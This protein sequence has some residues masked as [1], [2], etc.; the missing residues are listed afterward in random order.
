MPIYA[1]KCSACGFAKDAL[2]KMSDAPLTV[3]P[4]CGASTFEKQVTAAGFQ[5]KGSGWYVTDF[6][7]GGSGKKPGPPVPDD[8]VQRNFT[9]QAPNLVWLGDITEH[10]TGEGELYGC[11][12][13]AAT[14]PV[15]WFT[16]TVAAI[17]TPLPLVAGTRGNKT[18]LREESPL[19]S[20]STPPRYAVSPFRRAIT[21]WKIIH[22]CPLSPGRPMPD[23]R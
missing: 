22:E 10:R 19:R 20:P 17:G 18:R 4:A 6:R 9:T 5:L 13:V 16:R 11:A 3:C 15:A 23:Q 12:R 8:L 2:Q 14:W 1:Y 7:E 21:E